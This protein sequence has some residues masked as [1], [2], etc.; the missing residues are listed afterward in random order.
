MSFR[1]KLTLV[2]MAI[3][4]G[5]AIVVEYIVYTFS[6]EQLKTEIMHQL[7]GRV[8]QTLDFIDRLMW[9]R[10]RD[11]FGLASDRTLRDSLADPSGVTQRLREFRDLHGTHV[12]YAFFNTDGVRVADTDGLHLGEKLTRAGWIGVAPGEGG[13][14]RIE[15]GFDEDLQSPALYFLASVRGDDGKRL[16]VVMC[17]TPVS[18]FVI[19]T[20]PLLRIDPKLRIDLADRSGRLIYSS[21]N[22]KAALRERATIWPL[23]EKRIAGPAAIPDAITYQDVL[24]VFAK[25]RGVSGYPAGA[26]PGNGWTLILGLP[27][28]IALV[29]ARSLGRKLTGVFGIVLVVSALAAWYV[30][31]GITRPLLGLQRAVAEISQGTF[32]TIAEPGSRDEIGRL[33]EAF[34]SMSSRLRD[35][36]VSRDYIAGLIRQMGEALIVTDPAARILTVNPAALQLLGYTEAE[37]I[38]QPLESLFTDEEP[39]T[40]RP[41]PQPTEVH[42]TTWRT[43]HDQ[44]I[45]VL[46]TSADLRDR[47]N[48][49]EG[50]IYLGHDIS[51]RLRV[52]EE[53]RQAKEAAEAANRAKSEFLAN[54]S[55]ELRTPL[56]SVLG[57]AQLLRGQPGLSDSQNKALATIQQSGE[58]LLGLIDDILDTAKIEAGTLELRTADFDLDRLLESIAAI[59]HRRAEAKG[60]AFT[61]ARWSEIPSPVSGDERRLRQV[62]V[63]L[64]DNAIKYTR[65]GGIALK[66]GL[67]EERV[68]FLVEDTGIGIRPEHRTEIFAVFHQVRDPRAAVE[69]TGLGLAISRRLVEL[70]GG[71]LRVASSPG[72]GSR[73]WFDLDL[74]PASMPAPTSVSAERVV[75]GVEGDRRRVLVVDDEENGRNLLRDLLAPLGFEVHEA[76]DGHEAVQATARQRPDVI[77]MDMRMPGLDGLE[78]TRRIRALPELEHTLI[79]AVSA[80]AFEHN[81]ARCLEAGA[82][83]FLPKPF[84]HE[85]LLE[86]L[87]TGLGL[88]LVCA[89]ARAEARDAPQALPAPPPAE[90]LQTM[91]KAARRG[92]RERLIEQAR[93]AEELGYVEFAADVRTLV[94]GFE[95]RKL[96][97]W[98]ESLRDP[99]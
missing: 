90:C 27:E 51:E 14:V 98:L 2:L 65:E 17:K 35:T 13:D 4:L 87:S 29:P 8:A 62:L 47:R 23:I 97:H 59:M 19:M 70:M 32:G 54:M 21:Y 69:G 82:D 92:D 96:R 66:V 99:S 88:T 67:E 50:R 58:H 81:R 20:E 74:P 16:G 64:L 7:R 34:N 56:N 18:H 73:F 40:G 3:V 42:E 22:P 78:A 6:A 60:L 95:M 94:E 85:R 63:N 55:H 75:I 91:L 46:L 28:D 39:P 5:T 53:L 68:C 57:Y 43:K 10:S 80:S 41:G 45:P 79:I 71:E 38:G 15:I 49:V 37:L 86:L 48:T 83:D 9:R 72:E 84:R 12:S 89:D 77:L 36:T 24:Y 25:E 44:R 1:T 61:S 93:D 30:S 52:Q 33:T 11:A 26:Y 76:R 31:R